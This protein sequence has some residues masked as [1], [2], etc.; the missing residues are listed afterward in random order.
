LERKNSTETFVSNQGYELT[1]QR[2]LLNAGE[3]ATGA[4]E[5]IPVRQSPFFVLI[6]RILPNRNRRINQPLNGGKTSSR[7][8]NLV[9][10]T[11]DSFLFRVFAIILQ[12]LRL[13]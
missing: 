13:K 3:C 12:I 11:F 7:L 9:K 5:G 10:N 2:K 4:W 6:L 8:D 1:R